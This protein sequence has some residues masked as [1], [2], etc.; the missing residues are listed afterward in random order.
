MYDSI[1][2]L[3]LD[4]FQA[5][6]T[7]PPAPAGDHDSIQVFRASR[8][9]LYYQLI[10]LGIFLC[11]SALAL[12]VVC[13]IVVIN[14]PLAGIAVGF[15]ALFLWIFIAVLGYFTIRLEYDMRYYI[16]TDRSLRIRKGVWNILEQTLTFVNIQNVGIEQGPIQ[17][18][19]GISTLVVETAGG[20]GASNPHPG[21]SFTNYHRA[22]LQ[23]LEDAEAFRD[24][25][26]NYLRRLPHT[27]GLGSPDDETAATHAHGFGPDETEALREILQELRQLRT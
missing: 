8:Q 10:F 18:A 23:G 3:L 26:M 1:K 7:A 17:R 5:P 14:F 13:T 21:E 20:G 27:S 19:M 11:A 9:F 2:D 22:T 24:L 16:V 12:L 25:I 4:L 15:L 6:K